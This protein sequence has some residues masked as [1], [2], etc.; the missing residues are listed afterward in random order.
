MCV[1]HLTGLGLI[2]RSGVSVL[3]LVDPARKLERELVQIR[4][5]S[6][7][8]NPVLGMTLKTAPA[9]GGKVVTPW[10][11][12]GSCSVS[13]GDGTQTRSRACD[14]TTDEAARYNCHFKEQQ[15]QPCSKPPCPIDGAWSDWSQWSQCSNTCGPGQETRTRTCTNPAPEHGGKPCPGDDSE[16]RPCIGCPVD[17]AWSDWSQWSQCSNTCGPGQETRT[18]TCT[19]PAPEHGGK[20]C[21]GD[22]SENRPCIGCPGGKVVTPWSS[23]GSCSVSCGDG[24]QTRSR[25]CDLTTDEAAR[26]NCHFKEQQQ[27]PCSKPPCPIDGAWS[28]WSQWSQCSN[29]CGPGQETRTR[30]CTN[31]APEHGGKPCPGDDSE[32]RPCIGCPGGKVVTPWS[33]WGSCSVSCGDG[34]QTRSR[35]CD[36]TTDEAARYNCHFKEQQQQP[37]SKPPC[38][39]DGAWS[40]WSQWSQCSNTCGPGQETRTR[41]CTNPAPEHGGKPCPGDDSENRPCIGCPGGKVVTPWSSWG[42]CS[43]SCGDGTQTRSRAC[44]LTTDEAA[45]YNCHFKEQQQQPCSKPPCPIDGAWSDWSQWSQCSNTCGPGQETRTRTCTNPAPEHGGKPCPGDDSENRPCIGCPGGKVVTP[46]SSWGSCSVSCGDGT[47]TRSRACDLTTDEAARYNCHFKEQQQQPCSKPPCPIDGAWSDWSQW[48]QCSN[49]CGP[50]QETRTRTC[51]NPAP[52]HGGKPCPGDDSENRPCI[53]C[54]GGK[55]VTPWSSWGSCSVSCGDGTQTRSRACDLTTDEA[56]RYNCHFKEQQQQPCSK[57]PC[58]IDGAWSDW[59]QW[60][61]CS[62]TCGP[63]QETRTRTCTNPA[64]EHGG[65]PCPGDDSENRPCIGCPGGKVVTPWSSWGSCSVSCGDGTQ[66]RSRACDL[67]TDEA[68]RYNCHFKEQQQQPCSKPPC[69]IDGAW[70]DWSQW[71]QCS[72]TCGPGQE[73]RTRTCTNPAPEHGGKPCPGDD[74]ENRPCIG[75]PGGKVVTPWSSWGSCSVSCGDGTQTRSRACDLTTDEAARYNCHFKEQQQQPC[76][77]PPC[78]IDGA[79]SDWSQ[80]SQCS[81]T[82]GPGQETRTRTCTNPAPEH[83]GKPCPGDDSENRPCIGCPGGKVVTP[84]SSWGSC[85]VSCGDG[86]QT[87]SRACDLTT[88]EAARYNCHFKEQQQQPCSK[89]PCP[90]DGAWSDWSQWSQC[91][92]TCGPGQETRTRTCT[93]PAPEHGGKPCPG[94]DSE[95]RPCIGCPGGKVVTPWSSWGS[96][97]VSCGDGTQTR[98]RAC[99]LTTD[100]AARYNCHFKEQ[101]QQPCSKPPCP[102]DG[103]WSDW[104][105]W[106]QCSNT[107]GPGQETRTRTCTNPAPE[108]G[109]KPCPGDDSENRPCIGCPGG[110]VV[111]PWSSWGSCSVSCGDGT[112]TRSRACDLTTDEAARYNCHFK[113]QQQQPCSKPPCPIDGAWSDWSQWSQCSNTCGPGQETRTRTC[114]NPAPEHGGKPCPGDDSENRPCI[115]CPGGKVVTPWSSWGSCSVSCGDGTQTRSRACDLTTDEAARYNCHFKEQQQQPCSKPPC[116]IDGHWGPWTSWGEC[117][118]SSRYR[119]RECNNPPPKYGGSCHGTFLEASTCLGCPGSWPPPIWTVWSSCSVTCGTGKRE[120]TRSCDM[121]ITEAIKYTCFQQDTETEKCSQPPC[122]G[123]YKKNIKKCRRFLN[124]CRFPLTMRQAIFLINM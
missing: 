109:G 63:G 64:P 7:E 24:T 14:L 26:Y 60:S 67:T 78:P 102:I 106:S 104:S 12:W 115:G 94:D 83:G 30:T 96:C 11:S 65:K 68:A 62:N 99:D 110:K 108:H 6:M 112:Q 120:R 21:P 23:W 123:T 124:Q 15:Q 38:P 61:Q 76:S 46:W 5:Q 114:T 16:N 117:C 116:P 98:S 43:V 58:P 57:P 59:S 118:V 91:S 22:D 19:N 13:C 122:T 20:P 119:K 29:T 72:N 107:C 54:P 50:G 10:S 101:Q 2:G 75:C 77:K 34:T 56:A 3:T 42:S 84:W 93:N 92:N 80:W 4:P 44:D 27:Q 70:S 79:W 47:Q 55:V 9:L 81:N 32:N 1:L 39:I 97:S 85:S 90:I 74:S 111:T 37:C 36:L 28:D 8:A 73:T 86:T 49:T 40:D 53:G 33:S 95:N 103:A 35:A 89:P 87:R 100:E 25:A 121:P 48:S 82:C 71:S 66:T 41:T 105:Q 113:E 52:E 51:T 69:P 17:G 18:R 45:R 31:P 88:D